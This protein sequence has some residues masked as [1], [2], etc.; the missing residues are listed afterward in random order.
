MNLNQ[1]TKE[2]LG[3]AYKE[4]V[5]YNPFEDDKTISIEEVIELMEGYDE[6]CALNKEGKTFKEY[7][8]S[9]DWVLTDFDTGQYGRRLSTYKY[10]F[11]ED[12][13]RPTII[14]LERYTWRE[15]C[16]CCEAYYPNM[17]ELFKH[18][19]EKSTWIIAE[20]LFEMD[21]IKS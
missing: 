12:D 16:D 3:E 14:D 7:F 19:A 15:I 1:F 18:Y 9:I 2:Q 10:E 5:G 21:I 6:T 20:C 8:S 11:K 13:K 4:V 17:D